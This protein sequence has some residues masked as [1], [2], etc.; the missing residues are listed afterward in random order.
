MQP[1][2]PNVPAIEVTGLRKQYRKIEALGGLDMTVG[3][4]EVFGFLGPNGAGKTTT[5]RML[6]TLLVPSDGEAEIFGH[7]V[8]DEPE[9]V[10]L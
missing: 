1:I 6:V 5:V 2:P 10:R 7:S 3:R 8:V 4:S 9:V